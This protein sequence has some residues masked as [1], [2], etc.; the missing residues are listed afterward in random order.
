MGGLESAV[1]DNTKTVFVESAYFDPVT[2]RKGSKDLGLIT[3]ASRRFERGA[4]IHAAEIAL[5]R[6][7]NLLQK[8]AGGELV[9]GIIDAYPGK[10]KSKSIS[11]RRN[12]LDLFAGCAISDK[13]VKTILNG[14]EIKHE[15]KKNH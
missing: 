8:H 15:K 9:P 6:V 12:E 11:L 3:D 10:F 1:Q 13:E 14:L 7:I 4:D 2:I 5:W